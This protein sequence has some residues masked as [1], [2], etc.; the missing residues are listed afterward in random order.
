MGIISGSSKETLKAM[1]HRARK[2]AGGGFI[3][4]RRFTYLDKELRLYAKEHGC[5]YDEAVRGARSL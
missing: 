1:Y 2:E 4:P 5:S 3:D